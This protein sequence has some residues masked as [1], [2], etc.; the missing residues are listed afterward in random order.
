MNAA[1]TI[2]MKKNKTTGR[3]A[4]AANQATGNL[5]NEYMRQFRCSEGFN[6]VVDELIAAGYKS[7]ADIM[8]EALERLAFNKLPM[9]EK[10]RHLISKI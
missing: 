2:I 5:R 9:N 6:R 3:P 1:T 4:G 7:K 10:N 8:H